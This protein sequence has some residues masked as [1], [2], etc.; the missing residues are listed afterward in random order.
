ME[1]LNEKQIDTLK[2]LVLHKLDRLL[3]RRDNLYTICLQRPDDT[4]YKS[5]YTAIASECEF[6]EELYKCI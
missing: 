2:Y 6:L 5:R 3:S 1:K 4:E